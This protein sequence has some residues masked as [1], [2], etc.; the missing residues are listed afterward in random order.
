MLRHQ[1]RMRRPGKLKPKL[2]ALLRLRGLR[3]RISRPRV[4]V[5]IPRR[6]VLISKIASAYSR[7]GRQC[8][9]RIS[10]KMKLMQYSLYHNDAPT[11]PPHVMNPT[12]LTL[13]PLAPTSEARAYSAHHMTNKSDLVPYLHRSAWIPVPS[14]WIKANERGYYASWLGLT[15]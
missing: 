2:H 8:V 15:T 13:A 3:K 14:T 9:M 10:L 1:R 4:V 5:L 7:L 11:H 12:N 6:N